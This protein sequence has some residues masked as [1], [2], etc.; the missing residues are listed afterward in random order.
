VAKFSIGGKRRFMEAAIT[1]SLDPIRTLG[2]K[3]FRR[4]KHWLIGAR[5][6]FESPSADF[7]DLIVLRL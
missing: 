7:S 4:H 2:I 1:T 6:K 3:G 5:L